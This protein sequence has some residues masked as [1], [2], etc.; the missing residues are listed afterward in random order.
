MLIGEAPTMDQATGLRNMV[1]KRPVQVI[2]VTGGKGGIG[3]TNV[4]V[5]LS[6]AMANKGKRVLLMDADLGLSNVDILLGLQ[7][8]Y[9]L[10]H[11]IEGQCQLVDILVEARPRFHVI[12]ASSGKSFMT[13]LSRGE[14]AGIIQAFSAFEDH[15]DTLIID[16]AAG[17]SESVTSFACAAQEVLVVVCDEPA[18]LTDAYAQIKLLSRS[19]GLH[20]FKILSN[21]VSTAQQGREL[22]CKLNRATDQFLDVTLEYIGSVPFDE[23]V[24]KAIM[25]QRAV[26]EAYPRSKSAIAFSVLADKASEWPLPSAPGGHMEFFVERLIEAREADPEALL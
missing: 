10:S 5:N 24:R 23:S 8:K 14:H 19:H 1:R 22:F 26:V 4:S 20:K 13:A 2:A 9:N 17:V 15:V 18:S 11:V 21:M 7:P 16:T 25:K 3:K 12:P 6:M